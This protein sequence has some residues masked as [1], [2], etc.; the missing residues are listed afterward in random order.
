MIK[1]SNSNKWKRVETGTRNG[2][3]EL[4]F[5]PNGKGIAYTNYPTS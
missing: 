1:K 5:A 4:S 2:F 3:K